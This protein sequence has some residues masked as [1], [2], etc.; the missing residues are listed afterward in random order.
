MGSVVTRKHLTHGFAVLPA[1]AINDATLS[2]RARGVL[3]YMLEKPDGWRFSSERMA[4]QGKEGRDAIRAAMKE[5]EDAGYILRRRVPTEDGQF[6]WEQWIT[7]EPGCW[8]SAPMD[9]KPVTGYP[10]TDN[11]ASLLRTKSKNS[12]FDDVSG[13]PPET[14][15]PDGRRSG[16]SD[17]TPMSELA[18]A[19][20]QAEEL[21][22]AMKPV[23]EIDP[24]IQAKLDRMSE[25]MRES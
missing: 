2:F 12:D 15:L 25:K 24:T 23:P 14:A 9:G 22:E 4:A 10:T 8:K 19:A 21:A 11:Q 3:A 16:W 20:L 5:L 17:E 13:N 7:D 18:A 1:A 6:T